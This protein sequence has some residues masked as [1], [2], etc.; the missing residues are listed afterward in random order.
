VIF[1]NFGVEIIVYLDS[2]IESG[3]THLIAKPFVVVA[4]GFVIDEDE[5]SVTLSMEIMGDNS[6][7]YRGQVAIPKVSLISRDVIKERLGA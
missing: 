6:P 1:P 4:V 3:Q 5:D 7:D 2:A